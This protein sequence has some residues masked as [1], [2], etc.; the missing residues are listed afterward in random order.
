MEFMAKIL[1]VEDN[2]MNRDMLTRRLVRQGF[3]VCCAVDGPE[4]VRMAETERPAVILTSNTAVKTYLD[5]S[6]VTVEHGSLAGLAGADGL[7]AVTA[8]AAS[9]QAA[10]KAMR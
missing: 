3:E 6:V 2:E 10:S 1:L 4:G 5:S 7:K 8:F 9:D